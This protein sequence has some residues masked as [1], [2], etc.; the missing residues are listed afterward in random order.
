MIPPH[1]LVAVSAY[2]IQHAKSRGGFIRNAPRGGG[3]G[4]W[5]TPGLINTLSIEE[6]LEISTDRWGDAS[7]PVQRLRKGSFSRPGAL[8]ESCLATQSFRFYQWV[9]VRT[10]HETSIFGKHP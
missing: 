7:W 9:H 1:Q 5:Q 3:R 2:S 10:E 4:G 6:V 8:L